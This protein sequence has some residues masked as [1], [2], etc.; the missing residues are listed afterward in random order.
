MKTERYITFESDHL[1]NALNR[2]DQE[3]RDKVY[4]VISSE[5]MFLNDNQYMTEFA[6]WVIE[7]ELNG[8]TKS[9]VE[10]IKNKLRIIKKIKP[11]RYHSLQY[12]FIDNAKHTNKY[13]YTEMIERYP[14]GRSRSVCGGYLDVERMKNFIEM[15]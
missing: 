9:P 8:E 13:I 11:S 14:S 6:K 2:L 15:L 7:N 4:K 1:N 12:R 3:Q 5:D 10:K